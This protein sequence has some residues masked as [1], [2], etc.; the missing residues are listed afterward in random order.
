MKF[1]QFE[2]QSFADI[3]ESPEYFRKENKHHQQMNW[4]ELR[5]YI[6]DLTQSG[7][8]TMG[9]QVLWHRKLSFPF[10]AFSMALLAA[11]FAILTGHRGAL[12]PVAFSLVLAIAYYALREFFEKLGQAHLLSP[13]LAAWAPS[14]IF[15]LSGAYLFLRVRT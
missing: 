12:A 5:D 8:D 15:S 6:L 14:V 11:P 10:F 4:D 1:E 7:F 2:R 9:L 13:L 3:L